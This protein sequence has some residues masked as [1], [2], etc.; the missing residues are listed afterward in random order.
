MTRAPAGIGCIVLAAGAGTRFG[1]DKR[2]ADLGGDALLA[3]TLSMLAPVFVQRILVLRAN[4]ATDEALARRFEKDWEVVRAA[5][6]AKGMG[7][8]L[9]AAMKNTESWTGAVIALARRF[10]KDWEV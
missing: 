6:A 5:D 9:A 4:H 2:L 10:E 1:S 3:R 7:H 8:S